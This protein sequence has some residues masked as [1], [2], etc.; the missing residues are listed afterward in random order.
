MT[1]QAM[2]DSSS[3]EIS[4]VC[5]VLERIALS[6]G[7]DSEERSAIRDG[8]LAYTVV[9]QHQATLKAF[10]KLQAAFGGRISDAMRAKLKERG[11]DAEALEAELLTELD[12]VPNDDAQS[13]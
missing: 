12:A 10:A 3:D 1:K 13:K 5:R 9:F 6:Y 2:P 8:A 4:R 11:I 7:D